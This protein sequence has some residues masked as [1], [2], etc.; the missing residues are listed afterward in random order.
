VHYLLFYEVAPGYVDR[1]AELRDDHLRL[2]W[3]AHA[4]GQLVL[5]GALADDEGGAV[6]LF[7]ADSS[8]VAEAF[9]VADPYVRQGLV[10]RW[11]VREWPT[12]VGADASTPVFP[13]GEP[14]PR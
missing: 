3:A 1:R 13:P 12:V 14:P 10:L 7:K 8:A 4:R 6:L 5:G 9:A 11:H 2:A